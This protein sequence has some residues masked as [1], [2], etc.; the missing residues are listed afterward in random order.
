MAGFDTWYVIDED[1]DEIVTTIYGTEEDAQKVYEAMK[2][3]RKPRDQRY[4]HTWSL[5]RRHVA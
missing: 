4:W 3:A 5:F 1:T 2:E